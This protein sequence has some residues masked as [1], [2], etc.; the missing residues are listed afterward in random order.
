MEKE[1]HKKVG[2][3]GGTF[4]P[5]HIAHLM[6]AQQACAQFGLD[7]VLFMP[8]AQ[9]PHKDKDRISSADHRRAMT[10]LAVKGNEKFVFSDLEIQR[11]GTTYTSDTLE[12][13]HQKYSDTIFYFIMGA[14]SLFA[15]DSWYKPEA[16]FKHAVILVGN[17][18]D[19][20]E[21]EMEEQIKYLKDRF[22]GQIFLI[23]MPDIAIS[24]REVRKRI[25]DG[26]PIRYYVPE[27]VYEYIMKHKLYLS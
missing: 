4:D 6:L 12:E 1:F 10:E 11:T 8:C 24:S 13:L 14:D 25:K 20:P 27:S 17:R 7:E 3:M 21:N 16:I 22:G 5:I 18:L 9:P 19:I 26:L 15:V 2:I 23:D